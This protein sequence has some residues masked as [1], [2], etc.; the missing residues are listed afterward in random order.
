[1]EYSPF[2]PEGKGRRFY[3]FYAFRS[4]G[5]LSGEG[6]AGDPSFSLPRG[7]RVGISGIRDFMQ[8][9]MQK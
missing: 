5:V 4:L 1:M 7:R 2:E 3:P 9:F 6:W 8:G